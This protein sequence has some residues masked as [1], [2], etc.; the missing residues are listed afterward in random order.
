MKQ[1]LSRL[2]TRAIEKT[3]GRDGALERTAI[4][5]DYQLPEMGLEGTAGVQN[6]SHTW[7]ITQ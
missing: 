6:N 3:V 7:S 2:N 5:I 1:Y 4:A